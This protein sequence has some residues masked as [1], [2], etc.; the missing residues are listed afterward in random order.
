ML[1]TFSR[2]PYLLTALVLLPPAACA[3]ATKEQQPTGY[4]QTLKDALHATLDNTFVKKAALLAAYQAVGD[5]VTKQEGQDT[6]PHDAVQ[7][8]LEAARDK[9]QAALDAKRTQL[10]R[11]LQSQLQDEAQ[12]SKLDKMFDSEFATVREQVLDEALVVFF[13][14]SLEARTLRLKSTAPKQA[15][16]LVVGLA[17]GTAYPSL[18]ALVERL[19]KH[20]QEMLPPPYTPQGGTAP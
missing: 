8:G 14:D 1:R 6:E 18:K 3:T 13:Q 5:A 11:Q 12:R 16:Y 9:L 19:Q 2:L 17:A 7:E 20:R 10:K 4:R 15:A